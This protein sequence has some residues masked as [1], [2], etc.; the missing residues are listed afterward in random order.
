MREK[1]YLGIDLGTTNSAAALF[2][3]EAVE[4][5]RTSQGGVLTPSVVRIDGRGTASV[6]AKARR[7]L[8]T[9][10]ENTKSEFKRLMGTVHS[11]P[12]KAAQLNK[13]PEELAAEVLRS[14]CSDVKDQAGFSPTCAV[15]AV[16][17]L[18]E[19]PQMSATSEAARLAGLERIELIQEPVAS[20]IAAGYADGARDES[21]LVYDL[22]GGTFDVSLVETKEGL[23]RVVGHDGNNFLGGRD[24]D[25]TLLDLLLE[26]LDKIGVQIRR[27][28]PSHAAA[29]TRL[30]LAAEEAKIDLS[31]ASETE[32]IVRG[33]S[34]GSESIDI[35]QRIT[36]EEYET[37]LVP[38]IDLTLA[39]SRRLLEANGLG[40]GGLARIVLVGGPTVT[41]LLRERV[42]AALGA[43]LATGHDPMTLVA[44]GAA[45]FA[46]TVGLLA[47]SPAPPKASTPKGP[48]VWLQ[49]P[50]LTADSTP[51]VVG[52][53]LDASGFEAVLLE[54]H[55]GGFVSEPE[56]LDAEG[57]FAVMVSLLPR[58]VSH[59]H[60]CG[61]GKDGTRTPLNP[62]EFSI[63][64][65]LTIGEPPLSRSIGVALADDG[66]RTFF[67]RGVPL[68]IRRTFVLQ[69]TDPVDPGAGGFA[70]R[71]PIVQGEFDKAHLCR[72]VGA[73][74]VH[75]CRLKRRVPARTPVEVTLD[76]DRGGR[77]LATARIVE[78]DQSFDGVALLVSPSVTTGT[79]QGV[80]DGLRQR[81]EH[82]LELAPRHSLPR[83][84]ERIIEVSYRLGDVD[85]SLKALDGGDLD[86][87]EQA[88][89][90]LLEA[91]ALLANIEAELALPEL[92]YALHRAQVT[93]S[94]W[95]D[96]YGTEAEKAHFKESSELAR[97]ALRASEIKAVQHHLCVLRDLGGRAYFRSPNAWRN[98]LEGIS[99]RLGELTDPRFGQSLIQEGRRALR[100]GD[101]AAVQRVVRELWNLSPAPVDRTASYNSSLQDR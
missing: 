12:F 68:P 35:A 78:L 84:K 34:L 55:D 25:L 80:L 39:I 52:R 60:I 31:R 82:L 41:P 85:F 96:L 53:V 2:D 43:E 49:Y 72:L 98:E 4:L 73:L 32:L 79:M 5:V 40:R 94:G 13:R 65:G 83:L 27:S 15:I 6:G 58:S 100:D 46:G 36:R 48:A 50:A 22:G 54:R 24:L 14:L 87:G 59:F 9:D 90:A 81:T 97:Q 1:S 92:V 101:M 93:A 3:G 18:F 64:H 21:W 42:S 86:A 30:K 62:A 66:V 10:P 47:R 95:V 23:L 67:E 63:T 77:L 28:D 76:L 51:F 26:K 69:T 61:I 29:L 33:I 44:R 99:S 88:R 19:L 75:A 38:F 37:R 20:A 70:L 11:L 8:E 91:D 45:L 7:T 16:P 89:R 56:K 71:I 57:T 17:A 74:E